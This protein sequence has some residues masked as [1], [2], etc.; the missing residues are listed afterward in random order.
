MSSCQPS[1]AINDGCV[2]CAFAG[3]KFIRDCPKEP[4]IA[5]YMV[6]GGC[7]GLMKML[8]L[9]WG[10]IKSLRYERLNPPDGSRAAA[11]DHTLAT[12]VGTKIG[13]FAL[14]GFLLVWFVFGNYWIWRIYWPDHEPTLYK[15]DNW[16]HRTLYVFAV[17][18]LA[19]IYSVLLVVSL[20]VVAMAA[21]QLCVL[22][23]K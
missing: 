16:C 20:F 4:H 9:L 11:H 19:I 17:V 10:Q 18:H 6:V 23:C 15:P 22:R 13:C 12:S 21:I 8:W 2:G 14:T 5:V 3:S 1:Y 7:F